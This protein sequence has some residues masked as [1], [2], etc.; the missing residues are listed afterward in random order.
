MLIINFLQDFGPAKDWY[1]K[2]ALLFTPPP[3]TTTATAA[4][5]GGTTKRPLPPPC[6]TLL[7]TFPTDFGCM[8]LRRFRLSGDFIFP[9]MAA[10][11]KAGKAEAGPVVEVGLY[12]ILLH[13][14]HL[15]QFCFSFAPLAVARYRISFLCHVLVPYLGTV[16]TFFC[17]FN[18]CGLATSLRMSGFE[19]KEL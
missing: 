15:Q 9:P 5:G 11:A 18:K 1:V 13:L 2:D 14:R 10:R 16:H 19:T 17:I 6:D 7:R 4:A 3:N 8:R 12:A